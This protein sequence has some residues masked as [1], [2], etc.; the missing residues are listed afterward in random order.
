MVNI[1][2]SAG[3]NHFNRLLHLRQ[4][5]NIRSIIMKGIHLLGLFVLVLMALAYHIPDYQEWF[6]GIALVPL[7][8]WLV[9][10]INPTTGFENNV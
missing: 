7:L 9:G 5:F 1:N 3:G 8:A 4:S 2:S 10:L 6:V